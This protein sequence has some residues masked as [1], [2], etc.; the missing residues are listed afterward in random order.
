[1]IKTKRVGKKIITIHYPKVDCESKNYRIDLIKAL[2]WFSTYDDK[3][4]IGESLIATKSNNHIHKFIKS[5]KNLES[6]LRQFCM[7]HILLSSGS[8]FSNE[9]NKYFNNIYE[10]LS[11]ANIS[12]KKKAQND[13]KENITKKPSIQDNIK[14][15]ANVI[16]ADIDNNIDEFITKSIQ[17]P[18][19]HHI[20]KYNKITPQ[21]QKFFNETYSPLIEELNSDNEQYIEAYSFLSKKQRKTLLTFLNELI[22]HF[23]QIKIIKAP[24]VK[25]PQSPSKLVKNLKLADIGKWHGFSFKKK[26]QSV[27]IINSEI[28]VFWMEQKRRLVVMNALPDTKLTVQGSTIKNVDLKNSF[29]I[30]LRFPEEVLSDELQTMKKRALNNLLLK[31][32]KTPLTTTRVN[33]NMFL[34]NII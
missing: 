2:N 23:K 19:I 26:Y 1:M 30:T 9:H 21:M 4:L 31:L 3:D 27:E 22:E 15:K 25:K 11:H 28:L 17:L 16:I 33:N 34:V 10:S 24:R 8:T 13:D 20:F 29:Y 32:R 18:T 5:L 6:K 7:Y 12:P 14:T